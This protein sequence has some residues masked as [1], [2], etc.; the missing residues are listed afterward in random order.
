MKEIWKDIPGYEGLYQ[1]SDQGQV[2]SIERY[3]NN[4]GG[5]V[6][7]PEKVLRASVR[8]GYGL[9]ALS[10]EGV[11]RT[12]AVHRLVA[13]AFIPNAENKPTV[14]HINGNKL[15]NRAE[16]LEWN[17][18]KENIRHA[19][20]TGLRNAGQPFNN[21]RSIAVAQYDVNMNLLRVY[22]SI[23]EAERQTGIPNRNI[24]LCCRGKH[25]RTGGY[26]WKYAYLHIQ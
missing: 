8:N 23:M 22:P 24:A 5:F 20:K 1:V 21:K 26:I 9:V 2:K 15:D 4:N 6:K 16:N 25:K 18:D 10:K 12:C 19:I 13:E 7:V 3:K 11:R 14:N 17:T